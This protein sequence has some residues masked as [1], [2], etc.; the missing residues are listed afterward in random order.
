MGRGL[1][2]AA[3]HQPDLI[4]LDLGLPDMLGMNVLK[5]LQ[6]VACESKVIVLS[7]RDAASNEPEAVLA[8]AA[9]YL[10]KPIGG[11]QVLAAISGLLLQD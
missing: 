11:E 10:E 5:R 2:L 7:A 6:V 8:G 3:A 4:L 9:L 1:A